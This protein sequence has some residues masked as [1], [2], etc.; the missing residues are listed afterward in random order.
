MN[1]GIALFSGLYCAFATSGTGYTLQKVI[2]QPI[3]MAPFYGLLM[4]DM[5]NAM[6][7]GAALELVYC[8]IMAPG[9]A[10]P[11]DECIASGIAIPLA[12]STSVDPNAAVLLA[13]PIAVVAPILNNTRKM[14]ALR[15]AVDADKCAEDA[16]IKRLGFVAW[17]YGLFFNFILVFP[18]VFIAV[19]LGQQV[20]QP[21]F[22]S[23][24]Q[25]ILNGMSVAGGLLPVV[26]FAMILYMIGKPSIFPFF[27]IGFFACEF[28]GLNVT[29]AAFFGIPMAIIILLFEVDSEKVILQRLGSERASDDDDE[30]EE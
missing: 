25:W 14:L 19:L 15:I 10:L 20:I 11:A 7:I 29:T 21:F 9:A 4:G 13:T 3:V 26:G 8:G 1:I 24:P 30:D 18:V 5:Y 17:A 16:D 28:L 12:L 22:D 6:L 2:K 23:M 27:F